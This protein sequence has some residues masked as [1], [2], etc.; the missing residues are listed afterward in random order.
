MK[1]KY[2]SRILGSMG[3]LTTLGLATLPLA[4]QAQYNNGGSNAPKS[5]AKVNTSKGAIQSVP[6]LQEK[7]VTTVLGDE[8]WEDITSF[9]KDSSMAEMMILM[10]V[11]GSGM[12]HM[13]MGAMKPGM[14]MPGMNM[15]G[16]NMPGMEMTSKGLS[17]VV[18][19][20]SNPPI[21]GDNNLDIL[22]TDASGKPMVGLKLSTTVAMT[23]MDMGTTRPKVIEGKDGHYAVTVNFSMKGPWRLSLMSDAMSDKA[24]SVSTI[25]DFNVDGK[26]KWMRPARERQEN[27]LKVVLNTK[28]DSLKVGSNMLDITIFNLKGM[29]VSGAIVTSAVEM[30]SMDMGVTRLKAQAGEDGHYIVPAEFSMKGPWRVTLS[31]VQPKQKPFTKV[32]EFNI[33]SKTELNQSTSVAATP[34]ALSAETVKTV[35]PVKALEPTIEQSTAKTPEKAAIPV[36]PVVPVQEALPAKQPA[37]TKGAWKVTLNTPADMV[38][39]GSNLLDV[40]V[41][42]SS[43][44]PVKGAKVTGTVEM[45]S[46]DMGVTKSK[47]KEGRDGHYLTPAVFSM[48][49][50]WRMT[51]NVVPPGQKSFTKAF[52][53]KVTK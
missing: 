48:K 27:A 31:V 29:P 17:L 25:L 22:A 16:M 20:S 40:T 26:T 44:K 21:P 45:T 38:K 36:K 51:L 23:S 18:S 13:R 50:P 24:K 34:Q 7:Q 28:P 1:Q 8:N 6:R 10:M 32:L 35:E 5:S 39:V 53:F 4:A 12:E 11:G 49:G 15:P 52:E 42:D 33:G 30:T 14:K 37:D 9:G 47:A 41:L 19:L 46:M 2:I 43:G 3:F